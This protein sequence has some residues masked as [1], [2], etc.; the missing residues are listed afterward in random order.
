MN[1]QARSNRIYVAKI[2][3]LQLDAEPGEETEWKTPILE[4]CSF[5]F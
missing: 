4:K 3:N 1:F 5:L 2:N